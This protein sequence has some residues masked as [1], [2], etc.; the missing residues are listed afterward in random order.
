[1]PVARQKNSVGTDNLLFRVLSSVGR[2]TPACATVR[3]YTKGRV[4]CMWRNIT[5]TTGKNAHRTYGEKFWQCVDKNAANGCWNWTNKK[6]RNGY[7]CFT[8]Q[9]R[10]LLAHRCSF[11][12]EH[13]YLPEPGL[14]LCHTCDNRLCVNPAHLFVGT[15]S[16][17]IQD[18]LRKGRGNFAKGEKAGNAKLSDDDVI[19][20]RRLYQSGQMTQADIAQQFDVSAKQISVIVNGKQR[21]M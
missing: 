8:I 4:I 7:G 6:F 13:G 2:P 17:N 20:I 21:V 3:G 11:E 14:V 9:G 18:M 1:M 10:Y 19:I 5:I 16:D 15:P 12:L